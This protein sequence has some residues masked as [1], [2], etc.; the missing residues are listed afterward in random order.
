[1]L[2]SG[3][4]NPALAAG[5]RE[6]CL[7]GALEFAVVTGSQPLVLPGQLRV[8][9]GGF[10]AAI[11]SSGSGNGKCDTRLGTIEVSGAGNGR[12]MEGLT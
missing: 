3:A 9:Q 11:D 7:Q 10:A 1:M 8:E 6:R 2:C 5:L 4:G 12:L